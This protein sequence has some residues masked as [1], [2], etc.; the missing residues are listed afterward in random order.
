MNILGYCL[1]VG[2]GTLD[3]M[4]LSSVPGLVNIK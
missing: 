4:V 1:L 3:Q 2:H